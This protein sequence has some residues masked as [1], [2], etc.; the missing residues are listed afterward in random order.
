M[1]LTIV[2]MGLGYIG[3]NL[4]FVQFQGRYLFPALIPWASFFRWECRRLCPRAGL[5]GWQAV[6]LWRWD[7]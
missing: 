1:A 5:G 7:G 3:Y 6:W 4:E 2:L